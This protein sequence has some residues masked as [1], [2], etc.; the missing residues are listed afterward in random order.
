V[1]RYGRRIVVDLTFE[2]ALTET[3]RALRDESLDLVG[4][5]DVR[6]L[7]DRTLHHDFRRYVLLEVVS[8]AVTLAALRQDLEVGAAL[9]TT[10]A[11]F[12]LAD[13]ETAVVVAEPFSG[14]GSDPEW[15]RAAPALA[16]LADQA[17]EQLART[18]S[19]L[20]QGERRHTSRLT[21]L[22]C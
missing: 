12:E 6:A 17:C 15:R 4:C 7:L 8:P 16:A 10:V 14:L 20:E 1:D 19:R 11:V 21:P 5:M 22:L 13:G 9:P 3:I 18:L 2:M